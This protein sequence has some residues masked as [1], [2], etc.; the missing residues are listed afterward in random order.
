MYRANRDCIGVTLLR[1]ELLQ[2]L[3]DSCTPLVFL[4]PPKRQPR[5]ARA[6]VLSDG[7]L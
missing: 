1:A 7:E 6:R 3:P 2:Q 5:A 4:D